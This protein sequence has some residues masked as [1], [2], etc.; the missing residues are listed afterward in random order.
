METLALTIAAA[1]VL[2][3]MAVFVFRI[4]FKI[5]RWVLYLSGA[6]LIVIGILWKVTL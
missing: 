1:M 4:L 5:G 6:S 3:F 2:L